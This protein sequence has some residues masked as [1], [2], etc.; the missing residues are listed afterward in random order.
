MG[1]RTD[2]VR[3]YLAEQAAACRSGEAALLAQAPDS[4]HDTRVAVRRVRS[5]LRT[6][7][8]LAP[9]ERRQSVEDGLKEWGQVLGGVRDVE[10][11]RELLG[12]VAD[13]VGATEV[14]DALAPDLDRR[15]AEA[16]AAVHAELLSESHRRLLEELDALV[17]APPERSVHPRRRVRRSGRKAERRLAAAGDDSDALHSARKAAKR[18]RYAAEAIGADGSAHEDV[19]DALGDHRDAIAAIAHLTR[20]GPRTEAAERVRAAL[21][22]RAAEALGRVGR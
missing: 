12:G 9:D 16:W 5:T 19:Q 4:V 11:L 20:H 18:A 3:A 22:D 17:L 10:V 14:M 21:A 7:P 15:A 8:A 6:F 13:E 2:R 1:N